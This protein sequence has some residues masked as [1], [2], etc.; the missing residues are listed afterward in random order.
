MACY[1]PT[2]VYR[3]HPGPGIS[4]TEIPG[5][6]GSHLEIPCGYCIGCR[7]ERARQ[8]SVRIMHEAQMHDKSSFLTLTYDDDHLPEDFSLD[9]SD[10]QRFMKRMRKRYVG[11]N[12][13]YFVCGEYGDTTH[14]PHYHMCLF[15]LDFAESRRKYSENRGNT[16][17]SDDHLDDLWSM[18]SCQIGQLTIQSASYVS[19]YVVN[20]QYQQDYEAVDESTGEVYVRKPPYCAMS[21]RPGI[22]RT[23]IEKYHSEVY[24]NGADRCFADGKHH[25]PPRYYDKVVENVLG[26]NIDNLREKRVANADKNS[27]NNTTER[28]AVRERVKKASIKQLMRGL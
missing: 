7:L 9:H 28:L 3:M 11:R 18:G 1:H 26:K 16:L 12:L 24:D 5:R 21:L 19:R 8:W 22:G 20:K 10:I 27:H 15:G 4:F 25:R 17:Y 2:T 23:W 13:R 14:R 6:T